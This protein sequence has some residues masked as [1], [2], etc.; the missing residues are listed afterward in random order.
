MRQRRRQ[1]LHLFVAEILPRDR[2]A[3]YHARIQ[4]VRGDVTIFATR[5]DRPP[6]MEIQRAVTAPAWRSYRTAI[7]LRSV[8]PV[9][10]LIV[11][12]HVIQLRRWLVVPGTPRLAA[13]ARYNRALVAAESHS[14]RLVRINPKF[15]VVVSSGRAFECSESLSSVARL[16][17]CG[18]RQ[19]DGVGVLRIH[20]DFSEIPPAPPDPPVT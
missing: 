9:R 18:V 19:V 8:H 1:F 14:S 12:Y 7:L 4:R 16:V 3:K 17:S 2:A 15:V 13:V 10:K 11:R 6:I 5:V 20:A